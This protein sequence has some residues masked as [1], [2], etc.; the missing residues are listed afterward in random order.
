MEDELNARVR[1]AL[2]TP[3]LERAERYRLQQ[4]SLSKEQYQSSINSHLLIDLRDRNSVYLKARKWRA[5]QAKRQMQKLVRMSHYT[6]K[7]TTTSNIDVIFRDTLSK[8][9]Q[10]E[11]PG[12]FGLQNL[13]EGIRERNALE[14]YPSLKQIHRQFY[15]KDG[16]LAA[17]DS[18]QFPDGTKFQHGDNGAYRDRF[19]VLRDKYGPFWPGDW[20]PL[21]PTPRFLYFDD[22][23]SEPLFFHIHSKCCIYI[24]PRFSAPDPTF[25]IGGDCEIGS[26]IP[27]SLKDQDIKH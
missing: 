11:F 9:N 7:P 19:G 5:L 6:L 21:F 23:P 20:G 14:K 15:T 12:V 17:L 22:V 10:D 18:G 16:Y 25:Y 26:E 2:E 27:P 8:S 4:D 1:E 3:P 13:S 24:S